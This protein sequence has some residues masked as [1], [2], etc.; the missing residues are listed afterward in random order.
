[1]SGCDITTCIICTNPARTFVWDASITLWRSDAYDRWLCWGMQ[2]PGKA[3]SCVCAYV[4]I[5]ALPKQQH[6]G[7]SPAMRRCAGTS[8]K[9]KLTKV[10]SYREV[11][12][13][14]AI[15]SGASSG[16]WCRLNAY[17]AL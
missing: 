12:C 14:E 2:L 8:Y 1:M 9:L 4:Q 17:A 15:R 6:M 16:W 11:T 5:F 10:N 7:S 3:C 13:N